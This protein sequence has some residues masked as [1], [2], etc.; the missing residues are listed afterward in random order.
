MEES[1]I[2][3]INTD[4]GVSLREMTNREAVAYKRVGRRSN[5]RFA[6]PGRVVW[7]YYSSAN[8]TIV[9]WARLNGYLKTV[10]LSEAK[11]LNVGNERFFAALRMTNYVLR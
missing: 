6:G 5:G 4:T 8:V 2:G 3:L 9:T 7:F 10:T 11:V 1:R